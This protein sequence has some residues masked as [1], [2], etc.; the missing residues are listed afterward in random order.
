MAIAEKNRSP[1]ELRPDL[2]LQQDGGYP[3]PD[4]AEGLPLALDGQVN[5]V[6][7]RRTVHNGELAAETA[8]AH[9]LKILTGLQLSANRGWVGVHD[10]PSTNVRDSSIGD[11][12]R[13]ADDGL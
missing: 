3:D 4:I 7:P 11:R 2:A 1:R 12:W 10:G 8:I 9:V 5:V 13:V 6:N